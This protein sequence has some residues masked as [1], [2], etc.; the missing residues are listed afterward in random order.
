MCVASNS[1]L[2]I[3]LG[4]KVRVDQPV[5]ELLAI[6]FALDKFRSYLLGSKIIVFSDHTDRSQLG[7]AA[8]RQSRHVLEKLSGKS[9]YVFLDGYSG[10]MQIHIAPEDQ[11]K[12]TFTYPFGTFA[13]N[14]MPFGLCN[15]PSTFQR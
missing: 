15:A 1:A 4:H 9:H 6:V 12:T 5:H 10:Y 3:V 13:Y 7:R 11:H 8:E 14:H 2:G